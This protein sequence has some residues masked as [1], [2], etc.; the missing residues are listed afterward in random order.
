MDRTGPDPCRTKYPVVFVHGIAFRDRTVLARYWGDSVDYIKKS[1]GRA[2][3]GGQDAFGTIQENAAALKKRIME[4]IDTTG[5]GKVNI[6]AHSRGGLES[7]YMISKLGMDGHVASLTTIATPHR[8]SV[9]ADVI[10]KRLEPGSYLADAV[11]FYARVIGD[12]KPESYNAGMDLTV[13]RMKKFN[14]DVP[15]SKNTYYQSY[16]A[17]IDNAFPNPL[18]KRMYSIMKKYE[19]ENDGLVSVESAKWGEYRGMV[20]CRGKKLVSHADIIGMHLI[21][22][23]F[24]FKAPEFYVN[25]VHELKIKG[26]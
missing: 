17:C 16:A 18:W 15:D 23:S 9:M 5:C 1:G 19:G 10:M 24:C 25:L 2:Y 14:A 11:D 22:G 21:T 12:R 3:Y 26:Y 8:G 20:D 6:I 4:I 13:E 7:R